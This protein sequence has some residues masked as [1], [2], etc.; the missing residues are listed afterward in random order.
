VYA[1]TG[2]EVEAFEVH[3]E[4]STTKP[5]PNATIERVFTSGMGNRSSPTG[6]HTVSR[7]VGR[8]SFGASPEPAARPD[9]QAYA[10]K[11]REILER[12]CFQG[13]QVG[14][15][16]LGQRPKGQGLEDLLG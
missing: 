9:D 11:R 16:A 1:E 3:E 6:C 5:T 15:L 10:V 8:T 4:S 13:D 14:R 7:S 12:V 2:R